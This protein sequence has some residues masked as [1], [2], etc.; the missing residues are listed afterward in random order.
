MSPN[1]EKGLTV[2]QINFWWLLVSLK[3]SIRYPRPVLTMRMI[4]ANEYN[5]G[6]FSV[7]R[8]SP[9]LYGSSSS[10]SPMSYHCWGG[11][12]LLL[13]YPLLE[14]VGWLILELPAIGI[15]SDQLIMLHCSHGCQYGGFSK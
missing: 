3:P 2:G 10:Y 7:T 15:V 4:M 12:I 8:I 1:E 11:Y 13:S 14:V 9:I 6:R 5:D